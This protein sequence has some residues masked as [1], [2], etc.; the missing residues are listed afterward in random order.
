MTEEV[1]YISISEAKQWLKDHG[2]WN[3]LVSLGRAAA[4]EVCSSYFNRQTCTNIVN[5]I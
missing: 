4:I 3:K 5:S 1:V 2:L